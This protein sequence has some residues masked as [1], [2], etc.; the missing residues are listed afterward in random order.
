[1]WD[2]SLNWG[3]EWSTLTV[4]VTQSA[5]KKNCESWCQASLWS[6]ISSGLYNCIHYYVS[7]IINKHPLP[8]PDILTLCKCQTTNEVNFSWLHFL[9]SLILIPCW[10]TSTIILC[11]RPTY[12]PWSPGLETPYG[13]SLHHIALIDSSKYGLTLCLPQM[14]VVSFSSSQSDLCFCMPGEEAD[15]SWTAP[16]C[17]QG[18][19]Y[20]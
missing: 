13:S 16:A 11:L 6:N 15:Y 9:L 3:R 1:M 18:P 2:M 4:C 17:A 7:Q 14:N 10:S 19:T 8:P 12:C 20:V 5:V